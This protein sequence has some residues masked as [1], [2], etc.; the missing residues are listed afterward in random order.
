V[1]IEA[2]VSF[3][4]RYKPKRARNWSETEFRSST[5]V[6]LDEIS[7]DEAP[8]VLWFSPPGSTPD[9]QVAIRGHEGRLYQPLIEGTYRSPGPVPIVDG[10][11]RQLEIEGSSDRSKPHL[12]DAKRLV[13]MLE[14]GSP[15]VINGALMY[16]HEHKGV[17][18]RELDAAEYDVPE[19]TKA[20]AGIQ[21]LMRGFRLI[22]GIPYSVVDA[23]LLTFDG[24]R[25]IATRHRDGACN[26][27]SYELADIDRLLVVAGEG[28]VIWE[29]SRPEILRPDLLPEVDHPLNAD[30]ADVVKRIL[31]GPTTGMDPAN[32]GRESLETTLAWLSLR[33]GRKEGVSSSELLE[34]LERLTSAASAQL[35]KPLIERAR[36]IIARDYTLRAHD[37]LA[38]L[39]FDGL[40]T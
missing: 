8:I 26:V 21:R 25:K 22:D 39:S 17:A 4:G 33:D 36:A 35:M 16:A 3:T 6:R 1:I 2:S 28:A 19:E 38:D 23:P 13:G 5:P 10:A 11:V 40:A 24:N 31:I 34:R 18:Q 30:I 29:T 14:V 7:G 20:K 27:E 37:E 12:V 32:L 9:L 15:R